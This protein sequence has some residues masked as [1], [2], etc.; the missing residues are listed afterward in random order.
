MN[1]LTRRTNPELKRILKKAKEARYRFDIGLIWF[2]EYYRKVY[3]KGEEHVAYTWS[4]YYVFSET[5]C[6]R[7]LPL[8]YHLGVSQ[9]TWPAPPQIDPRQMLDMD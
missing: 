8:H 5:F 4:L 7:K 2:G 9:H 3:Q 6:Y 1:N